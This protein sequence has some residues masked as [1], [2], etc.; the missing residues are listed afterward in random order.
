[1]SE[2][3]DFYTLL[4]LVIAVVII[5]RLRSVLGQKR[6]HERQP[7]TI[8][9]REAASAG[10]DN[11]VRLP[12]TAEPARSAEPASAGKSP[13]ERIHEFL[14]ESNPV[15]SGLVEIARN[16][17]SFDPKHFVAGAKG[18]YEM[19]V[20]A[21]AQGNKRLLKQLL[22]REVFEGFAG[23]IS[24]R[25]SR[26]ET[27]DTSFVGIDKAD[28]IEADVK[29]RTARITVKF[30]SQLITA[31]KGRDGQIIDGDPKQIR[32]VT[33]IWTFAREVA[34]KDPNWKLIAT[35]AAN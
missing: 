11:V 18:A 26:G 28:I 24:D 21:F 15:A 29:N 17:A 4:F 8:A 6:G 9:S 32:E 3:F 25:E 5:L 34:S 7:G 13:E 14:P 22:S 33:D 27:V 2:T 12:R 35:Q 19:I 10:Q 31:I 16:D 30:V 23:A 20:T 1:M